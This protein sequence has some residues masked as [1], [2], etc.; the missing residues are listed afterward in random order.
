[1]TATAEWKSLNPQIIVI[2]KLDFDSSFSSESKSGQ[3]KHR[4]I[5][6]YVIEAPT[7]VAFS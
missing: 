5:Y 4:V 3:A 7:V 2:V 1:L 6:L